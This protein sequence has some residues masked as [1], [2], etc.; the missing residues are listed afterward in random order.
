MLEIG[1]MELEWTFFKTLA[2]EEAAQNT[3]GV[4]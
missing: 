3:S 1:Y 4:Y 2:E